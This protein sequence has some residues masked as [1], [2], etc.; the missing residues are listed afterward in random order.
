[1]IDA[2]KDESTRSG[3]CRRIGEQLG[4][5]PETLRGWVMQTEI[6]AGDR[7]GTTT[8]DAQRLADLEKEVRELR[9]ANAI[10]RSASAFFAAELD[11]PSH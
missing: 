7:A 8:S 1:M 3:A 6:D 9:R 10:L 11:R 2:K 5:N 4:I